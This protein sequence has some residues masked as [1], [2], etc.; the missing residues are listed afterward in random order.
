MRESSVATPSHTELHLPRTLESVL[1]VLALLML[2]TAPT[3][4]V[5]TLAVG[6]HA[7]PALHPAELLLLPAIAVWAVRWWFVRDT[8]SLP[9]HTHWLLIG[10]TVLSI[11]V[12]TPEQ[13]GSFLSAAKPAVMEVLQLVLYLL[14]AVTVFRTVF[15]SPA[16]VRTAVITLLAATTLAVLLGVAQRAL[17]DRYYQPDHTKRPPITQ[18]SAQAF[19]QPR[20]PS[21]VCG[22]FATWSEFGIHPSRAAYAGFL[23]L[24][25][26]FALALLV[27]ERKRTGIVM[28]VGVLFLG[29]AVSVLAG[30]LLPGIFAG[31]LVTAGALGR[32]TLWWTAVGIT[33]YLAAV[34]VVGGFNRTEIVQEPWQLTIASSEAQD[35]YPDGFRHLKRFWGEQQAAL[36]IFRYNPLLGVGA[37]GYQGRIGQ[38]FGALGDIDVQRSEPGAQNGYLVAAVNTGLLG[39][40]AMLLLFGSYW[41]LARQ[42]ARERRGA[43]WS[44][45][46]LGA[47]TA[48]AF[49][50]LATNPWV[51]GT[52]VVIVAIFAAIANSATYS[53]APRINDREENSCER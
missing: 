40:A 28:W 36:N 50:S 35:R 30:Y 37:G 34:V 12:I 33:V 15:T 18:M 19:L 11:F 44:A 16:R 48:L 1:F 24:V 22:P 5:L 51:R 6:R 29:A 2:A 4:V 47:V 45:A 10:T 39:L 46:L 9:P 20:L 21:N 26:P 17:L 14:V 7:L 23:A 13:G 32:R 42:A 8:R 49:V 3:Q 38:A 53:A 27:S 41:G 31:L 52:L 43:P 25:L